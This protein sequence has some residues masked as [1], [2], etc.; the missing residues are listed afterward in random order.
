MKIFIR[1]P[2]IPAL[3]LCAGAMVSVVSA[4]NVS[5]EVEEILNVFERQ[6]IS[7]IENAVA[8]ANAAAPP[9]QEVSQISSQSLES[10]AAAASQTEAAPSANPAT[11]LI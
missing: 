4:Q 9:V 3:L 7:A 6:R 5:P 8:P 1:K 10:P 2:M 11:T